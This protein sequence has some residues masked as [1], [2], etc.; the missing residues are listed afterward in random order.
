MRSDALAA[1]IEAMRDV[2]PMIGHRGVRVGLKRPELVRMQVRAILEAATAVSAAGVWVLPE[3]MVPFVVHA[4]ELEKVRSWVVDTAEAVLAEHGRV[5]EYR[6]GTMIELPRAALLADE[7]AAHAD[8]FSFGTNDL[9]QMVWGLSRDDLG[10]VLPAWIEQG[11]V[12]ESPMTRFDVPG[13]G[14]LVRWAVDRG[15]ASRPGLRC[16]ACGEH[17]GEP[18]AIAFFHDIGLDAVSCSPFRVPVARLAAALAA[19]R[20]P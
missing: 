7:I 19:L 3:I 18:A 8:F 15:R 20:D 11:V 9:T 10:N 17:A 13:V 12:P 1:R 5:V 4:G 2:N 6:V 16:V 14:A